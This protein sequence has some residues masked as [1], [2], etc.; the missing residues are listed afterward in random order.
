VPRKILGPAG[1][2]M[3]VDGRKLIIK[4]LDDLYSSPDITWVY[5]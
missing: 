1:K 5:K 3:T 2:E 4:E